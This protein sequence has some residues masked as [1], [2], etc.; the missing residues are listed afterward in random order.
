MRSS[1]SGSVDGP[2]LQME[3]EVDAVDRQAKI[4]QTTQPARHRLDVAAHTCYTVAYVVSRLANFAI[5]QGSTYMM[6]TRALV[7][8]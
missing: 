3:W 1:S 4:A 6:Y 8:C 2:P 5:L 7:G